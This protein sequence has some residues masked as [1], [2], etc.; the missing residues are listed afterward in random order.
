MMALTYTAVTSRSAFFFAYSTTVSAFMIG[1]LFW[2]MSV[3]TPLTAY[4][5]ILLSSYLILSASYFCGF[6]C[7]SLISFPTRAAETL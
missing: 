2:S 1:T 7:A 3:T 4:V 6:F 5:I